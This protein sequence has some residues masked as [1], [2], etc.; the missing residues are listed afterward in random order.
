[1]R[2]KHLCG[3]RVVGN[4]P[5]PGGRSGDRPGRRRLTSSRFAKEL[6][7]LPYYGVFDFLAFKYDNGVVTLMGYAYHAPL[8]TDAERAVKRVPGIKEVGDRIEVLSPSPSDDDVRWKAYCLISGNPFLSRY[9]PG[10]GKLWGRSTGS[11]ST[12]AP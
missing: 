1:M 10:G 3:G 7:K 9:A 4:G 12:S 5:R 8:T 11:R 2:T 6:L